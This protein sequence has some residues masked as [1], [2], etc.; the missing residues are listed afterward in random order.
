MS[1]RMQD[2]IVLGSAWAGLFLAG[3]EARCITATELIVD[4]GLVQSA[5]RAPAP[6]D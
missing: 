2:K 3:D 1:Q 4:G 5:M 6:G